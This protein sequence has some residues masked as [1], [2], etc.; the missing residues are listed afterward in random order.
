MLN[1]PRDTTVRYNAHDVIMSGS[2][3]LI[4]NMVMSINGFAYA[5]GDAYYG[6]ACVYIRYGGVMNEIRN[7]TFVNMTPVWYEREYYPSPCLRIEATGTLSG[8][9]TMNVYI[10]DNEI[11]SYGT[12][13]IVTGR[14]GKYLIFDNTIELD[15]RNAMEDGPNQFWG[16]THSF[17]ILGNRI[18]RG[19]RIHG[20]TITA[21]DFYRGGQGIFLVA[22]DTVGAHTGWIT[23]DSNTIYAHN[24]NTAKYPYYQNQ[25]SAL[26]IRAHVHHVRV[27]GN[28]LG[29]K[30][31][32]TKTAATGNG[33]PGYMPIG[34][35]IEYQFYDAT[36]QVPESVYVYNNLCTLDVKTDTNTPYYMVAGIRFSDVGFPSED[37]TFRFYNNRIAGKFN[38][39]YTFGTNAQV[40]DPSNCKYVR[41]RGD[42]INHVSWSASVIDVVNSASRFA[43]T[44]GSYGNIVQDPYLN[45]I[46]ISEGTYYGNSSSGM[47]GPLSGTMNNYFSQTVTA[48]VQA[49]SLPVSGAIVTFTNGYGTLVGTDTTD[50]T[51]Y[52][53]IVCPYLWYSA[54]VADSSMNNFTVEATKDVYSHDT[55]FSVAWNS[56]N[57]TLTLAGGSTPT[58]VPS[59]VWRN[60]VILGPG[61]VIIK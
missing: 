17:G 43:T 37:A 55:T 23:I 48:Y 21:G 24:G 47:F 53:S 33:G 59:T 5:N 13:G 7:C 20:N 15:G 25:G 57:V 36:A 50:G 45:N 12:H 3:N 54:N 10:H 44:N 19:S 2:Y 11:V 46:T 40:D 58:V 29:Y 22:R 31:D 56:H 27:F 42:T 32:T 38:W 51:G 60:K 8:T 61:K 35:A 49:S 41:V 18:G 4:E 30:C 26:K 52:A 1:L 28:I 34:A 6:N 14:E 16:L 9:D 39:A